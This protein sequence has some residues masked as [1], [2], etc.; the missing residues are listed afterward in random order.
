MESPR[1]PHPYP[2]REHDC[3]KAINPSFHRILHAL[4]EQADSEDALQTAGRRII[5]A[6]DQPGRNR[7]LAEELA[8]TRALALVAGWY[9]EEV[10]RAIR[11]LALSAEP[12][13]Q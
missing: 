5:Q 2:G 12:G 9:D 7:P 4:S 11:D 13:M 8:M 1:Y 3:R 10:E 6:L